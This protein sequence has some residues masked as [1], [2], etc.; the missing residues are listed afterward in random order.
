MLRYGS[1]KPDLR[2]PIEITD[3]TEHF[4]GSGFGLLRAIVEGGGVVRAIPAPGA[5]A[6]S[7]KFF[8]DMNDWA[9]SQGYAGLGYINIKGGEA[10]GPI[11]KNHGEEAT[12]KLVA[13]LGLGPDDGVFF[14][15]GKEGRRP[16]SP[17]SRAPASASS[18]A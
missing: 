9:R 18:S 14:A 11:A 4:Q 15:A 1:D 5:G 2:N 12:A 10:G 13:A 16:S 17:A 3:V 7:R 8:D 6:K